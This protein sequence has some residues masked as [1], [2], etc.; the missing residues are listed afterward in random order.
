[1]CWVSRLISCIHA[2]VEG[3]DAGAA[4]AQVVLQRQPGAVHLALVGLAAQL[5]G[6]FGA[7]C[8]ARGAQRVALAEQAARGVGDHLAA[9]AV[10]AIA[11][12]LLDGSDLPGFE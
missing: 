4:Q 10:V 12:E 6:E 2:L 11:D 5:P 9:V 8:Q 7:L 1:M 3:D